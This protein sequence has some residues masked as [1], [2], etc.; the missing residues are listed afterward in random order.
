MQIFGR[1]FNQN[2]FKEFVSA[3]PYWF[4]DKKW[5]HIEKWCKLC[6]VFLPYLNNQNERRR[7]LMMLLFLVLDEPMSRCCPENFKLG[8]LLNHTH[9]P[10]KSVLLS[11]IL[12]N[13]AECSTGAIA[14]NS[15]VQNPE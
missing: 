9:E 11:T 3:T 10:R 12:R 13:D 14:H 2:Y 6:D 7:I 8:G 1:Y 4:G 15:I 5:C